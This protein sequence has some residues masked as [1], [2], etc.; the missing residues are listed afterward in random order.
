MATYINTMDKKGRVI[1]PSRLRESFSG[2][3]YLTRSLDRGYLVLYTAELFASI[4]S[5]LAQLSGTDPTVRRLRR[6]ILGSAELCTVD[7]QG[8][9]NISEALRQ[10][11]NLELG[12]PVYFIET[13]DRIEICSQAQY[14][15]SCAEDMN[16]LQADLSAYQIAGL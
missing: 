7:A 14:E 13:G 15:F 10:R 5:Q 9:I 6:E 8:R 3:L 1:M 12:E 16:L 11:I 2:E 4:R